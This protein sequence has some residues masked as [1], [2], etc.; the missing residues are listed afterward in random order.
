MY[1]AFYAALLHLLQ[2][3]ARAITNCRCTPFSDAQR[4]RLCFF[5]ACNEP[6]RLQTAKIHIVDAVI[7][8]LGGRFAP[9]EL[10]NHIFSPLGA[11]CARYLG[12]KM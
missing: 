12:E 11:R 1:A 10:K 2:Q 9:A 4:V 5:C 8:K 3:R 7:F 6:E